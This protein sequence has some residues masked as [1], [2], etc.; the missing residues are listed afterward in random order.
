MP[1]L[2]HYETHKKGGHFAAM[3]V[4]DVFEKDLRKAVIEFLTIRK[5]EDKW[6]SAMGLG[7]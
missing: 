7:I 6:G 4:P 5:I 2:V 3:E 1:R